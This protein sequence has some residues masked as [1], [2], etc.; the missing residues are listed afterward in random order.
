MMLHD[1]GGITAAHP[2]RSGYIPAG[3]PS[4]G[5]LRARTPAQKFREP[6]RVAALLLSAGLMTEGFNELMPDF[7]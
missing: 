1:T 3:T 4:S 6:M 7:I 5:A 2:N